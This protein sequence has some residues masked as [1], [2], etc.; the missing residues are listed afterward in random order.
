LDEF[1]TPALIGQ[2][3]VLAGAVFFVWVVFRECVRVAIKIAVPVGILAALAIWS[4]LLD[5]T[6]IGAALASVG[7]GV[8]AG[9]LSLVEWIAA[10][11]AN[12]S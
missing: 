11:A 2:V 10:A 12:M 3:V 1:A 4:G 6:T 8:V 7:E 5:G 9:V